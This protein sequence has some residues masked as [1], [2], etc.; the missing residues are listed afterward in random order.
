MISKIDFEHSFGSHENS[1]I[2]NVVV[3]CRYNQARSVIAEAF[4]REFF[5]KIRVSSAG[6]Q[7][8]S[9]QGIPKSVVDY[10]NSIGVKIGTKISRN[11][12]DSSLEFQSSDLVLVAEEKFASAV[13]PLVRQSCRIVSLQDSRLPSWIIPSDPIKNKFT[14][15]DLDLE[16]A[17]TIAA[18]SLILNDVLR[19]AE[20]NISLVVPSSE[21]SVEK[22]YNHF[23]DKI[24]ESNC[25]GL[26]LGFRN[27]RSTRSLK[28]NYINLG[29]N[30]EVLE[31]RLI[32]KNTIIK[33]KPEPIS[34]DRF[35]LST[36]WRN[37]LSNFGSLPLV[38]FT[39]PIPTTS[40]SALD[41]FHCV[42]PLSLDDIRS[43]EI[44]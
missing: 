26:D 40:D 34:S 36:L 1:L 23:L 3:V 42:V 31:T 35:F 43:W 25:M 6:I 37:I 18:T 11:M 10:A 9:G 2:E 39:E 44:I 7:A 33:I 28:H 4:I 12:P 27:S 15:P 5:P 8:K 41:L 38:I 32:T 29:Y 24:E 20:L 14:S 13:I 22:A 19:R 30:K 17:K 16:L 21:N